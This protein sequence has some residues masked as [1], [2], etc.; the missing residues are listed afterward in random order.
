MRRIARLIAG[1]FFIL[2]L[3]PSVGRAELKTETLTYRI[4]DKE[5]TGYLAYDDA[6]AGQRPGVIVVR[7][8]PVATNEDGDPPGRRVNISVASAGDAS[9]SA[10]ASATATLSAPDSGR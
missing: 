3:A 9:P 4:G 7:T 8:N 1:G 5:F 2:M 10:I 6:I